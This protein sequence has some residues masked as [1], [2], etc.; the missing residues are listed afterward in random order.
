MYILLIVGVV[1]FVLA[2]VA[3]LAI[4]CAARHREPKP[5]VDPRDQFSESSNPPLEQ[6]DFDEA[7]LP[8][9]FGEG[10]RAS[11]EQLGE[12]VERREA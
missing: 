5:L 9:A 1:W 10:E 3:V 6:A 4:A 7:H 11:S 12:V 8:E 2:A